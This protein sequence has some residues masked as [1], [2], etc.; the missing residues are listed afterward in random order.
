VG[1]INIIIGAFILVI[2]LLV[3]MQPVMIL[4]DVAKSTI[5]TNNT[6]HYGTDSDGNVVP[7]GDS[8]FGA[9]LLL[10]LLAAIGLAFFVGFIIWAARGGRDPY[11]EFEQQQG[12]F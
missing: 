7:V 8:I 2:F 3:F 6:T 11:D 9:D 5:E 10:G 4:F 12:R 1:A